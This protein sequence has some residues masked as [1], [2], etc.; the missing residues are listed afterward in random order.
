VAERR[1]LGM[2]LGVTSHHVVAVLDGYGTVL[3]RRRC[4]PTAESLASVE[5]AALAGAAPGTTL[6]VVVEPTGPAWLPVAVFFGRRGHAVYRVPAAKA[7]DLRRF[8]SRHAKTNQIDAETLARLPLVD[9]AGL[10]PLELPGK[11]R[12]SLDRRVRAC[13]RLTNL[14]SMHKTRIRDLARQAFPTLN[15]AV[16]SELTLTDLAV[17]E[18]YG[19]PRAMLAAGHTQLTEFLS[20]TSRRR[21]GADRAQAWLRVAQAAVELFDDDPAMPF[22]DLA[23]ELASEIR[24]LRAIL[25]ERR[26]HAK[27]REA[28]YQRVDPDG[29]ARTLPGVATIG[30]PVL[31]AGM[32]R[33]QRFASGAAFK[34]FTGL[35]PGASETGETDRK[36]QPIS[37]AGSA[38]LR[39]QLVCSAQV[40][41]RLDPQ[42]AEVYHRQMTAHGAHH[43]KAV[44]VVAARLA[45]RAWTV[46]ARGE[47]YVLRD[48]DGTPVSPEQARRIIT[49]RYA[50]TDQVR[51]RRRSRKPR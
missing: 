6:E 41:R 40:A 21:M 15:D 11:L 19:D 10:R 49:E 32:G 1:L 36:G 17:L 24:L 31:V 45:E 3:V 26:M 43:T 12:A 20:I 13:D 42:L 51:R 4:R 50:I 5:A 46:L 29:L 48:L 7:A 33:P 35:T 16:P 34:A 25:A 38:R 37:K 39:D 9:P 44:C 22:A 8:L 47:P 23:A 28:A 14:T 30:G 2:D 18:R 27:G